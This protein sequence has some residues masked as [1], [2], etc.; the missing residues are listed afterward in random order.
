MNCCI[1][2][3]VLFSNVLLG[4]SFQTHHELVF[5]HLP[6]PNGD[7][8]LALSKRTQARPFVRYGHETK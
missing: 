7:L 4:P 5:Q 2:G 1:S 6:A 3:V 8:F